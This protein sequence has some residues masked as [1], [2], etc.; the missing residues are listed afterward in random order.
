MRGSV[1]AILIVPLV[2]AVLAAPP[3]KAAVQARSVAPS[4]GAPLGSVARQVHLKLR[5]MRL[6]DGTSLAAA[7]RHSRQAWESLSP[8][9][10]E[11]YRREARA[12]LQKPADEQ[13]R[14]LVHYETLIRMSA[15]KRDAYRRRA[16]WL[17][18]VVASFTDP[19]RA[20]MQRLPPKQRAQRL[21]ARKAELIRQ[22]K[23]APDA[24]R[25][26]PSR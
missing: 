21:L 1:V 13:Q 26:H 9:E 14:L 7:L 17:A 5:I 10:R 24:A 20:E 25:T 8:D 4:R 23:L 22:G 11:Q 18:V 12:F 16:R 6:A 3:T 2:G 15:A 19:Q